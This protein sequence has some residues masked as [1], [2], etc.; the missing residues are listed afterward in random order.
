MFKKLKKI[1]NSLFGKS[2]K[3]STAI[4]GRLTV[5]FGIALIVFMVVNRFLEDRNR[6]GMVNRNGKYETKKNNEIWDKEY[7][8]LYDELVFDSQRT[9]FE[10]KEIIGATKLNRSSKLLDAG[11][12]TGTLLKKIKNKVGA[13][14]GVD[15]SKY[16]CEIAKK[17]NPELRI[18]NDDFTNPQTYN[19][20][21]FTHITC[22]YFTIYYLP[23]DKRRR[24]FQNFYNWLKPGGYLIIHLVNR[25]KFDPLLN[26]SDPLHGVSAQTAASKQGKRLIES[27]ITM[28]E[29]DPISKYKAKFGFE[30][31]K[32]GM[33]NFKETIV[34]KDK[35]I[36]INEHVLY[37]DTRKDIIREAMSAGFI[38]DGNAKMENI[39][40]IDMIGCQYEYQYLYILQKPN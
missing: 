16:M 9:E 30:Q 38:N 19:P 39:K 18:T 5:V 17:R 21:E 24:A 34:R 29:E 15:K 28:K 40:K 6:E 8:E 23:P 7:C 31:I 1:L 10:T 20:N 36:R 22:L 3:N 11:S 12:G 25:N 37:M 14:E 27:M 2:K 4:W 32:E 33:A 35:S 13:S 26:Q